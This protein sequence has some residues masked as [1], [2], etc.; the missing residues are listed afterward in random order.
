MIATLIGLLFITALLKLLLH[1]RRI[2]ENALT[3]ELPS[4]KITVMIGIFLMLSKGCLQYFRDYGHYPERITGAS[5]SLVEA[6]YLK[7]EPLASLTKSLPRFSIIVADQ[8]G[9]AICLPNTKRTLATEIL[10]RLKEMDSPLAF[11]DMR[12]NQFLPLTLPVAHDSVN[13][14]LMLPNDPSKTVNKPETRLA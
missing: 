11:V 5:D 3:E 10:T 6:G 2:R 1:L 8:V 12:G 9:S 14:C 4:D 7:G 13:L